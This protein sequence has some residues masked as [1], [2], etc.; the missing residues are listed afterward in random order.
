MKKKAVLVGLIGITSF[1]LIT[2]LICVFVIHG[3]NK[4]NTANES[5]RSVKI[6]DM[7]GSC[8]VLRNNDKIDASVN[9]ELYNGD[10]VEVGDNGFARIRLDEDKL[11]YLDKGTKIQITATGDA[12]TSKTSIFVERGSLMTEVLNK[13]LQESSF[14]VVTANTIMNI[15]GTKTL[16]E[17][18]EDA[19]TGHVQTSNAVLEGQVKI[20]GV[21]VKSD[22]TVVSVE[23]DL[24]AG[25]GNSFSSVKEELVSQEEMKSIADTGST[26]SGV[27]VE[28]VTEEEADVV[29]D[30]ATFESSFLES[31][32]NILIT[33]A[34]I[35]A[36]EEGLSQE[37]IDSL[38]SQLDIVMR[39][40]EE[41][42]EASNQKILSLA[43][44]R[45]PEPSNNPEPETASTNAQDKDTNLISIL[46]IN[47]SAPA[48]STEP[49]PVQKE[50]VSGSV[51]MEA[52]TDPE[53]AKR[54]D[55]ASDGDLEMGNVTVVNDIDVIKEEE[56]SPEIII[57]DTSRE[58][59]TEESPSITVPDSTVSDQTQTQDN[60]QS[61]TQVQDNTQSQTQEQQNNENQS[62][63]QDNTE[64]QTQEQEN[65]KYVNITYEDI[66]Q[67][68]ETS[69]GPA[70]LK[71][72]FFK[73]NSETGEHEDAGLPESLPYGAA[74]PG[75]ESPDND[76][77]YI[78]VF[79][80]FIE[81]TGEES[82]EIN[83]NFS[84][85]G[86]TVKDENGLFTSIEYVPEDDDK[87][88]ELVLYGTI[89]DNSENEG[90]EEGFD[91]TE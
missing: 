10:I 12:A 77:I 63:G 18:I 72:Y 82:W 34:E 76:N 44:N 24:G 14:T 70:T 75:I 13:L 15:R 51:L 50:D 19:V 83:E 38:N 40:F 32:K 41:I 26:V 35:S 88:K 5:Q 7:G 87:L 79:Q 46:D 4:K 67:E 57:D 25:E 45:N 31:I 39:A 62:Q 8:Q 81:D 6:I 11:L 17:V 48:P 61:Q 16:T 74:L 23:K 58:K 86:W 64:T 68:V 37:E 3:I 30:V 36:G 22:G 27:T 28:V 54:I 78:S 21:K 89:I 71:L 90:L 84:F 91:V 73:I 60:T 85:N 9:M 59:K 80:S 65:N 49:R 2:V 69:D 47:P 29:F 1:A 56:T 43:D 53:V 42:R 33:D 20:K 52:A 66:S 55:D